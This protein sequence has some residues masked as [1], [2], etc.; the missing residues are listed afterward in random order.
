MISPS[1]TQVIVISSPKLLAK[2]DKTQIAPLVINETC[3][4]F[5]ESVK[6]LEVIITKVTVYYK[7]VIKSL[8]AIS[9][10]RKRLL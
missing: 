1:K 3:V 6:N 7:K 8:K 10:W 5:I 4:L 2:I 9:Y